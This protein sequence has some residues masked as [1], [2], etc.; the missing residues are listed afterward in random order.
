MTFVSIEFLIFAAIVMPLYYCLQRQWQNA[1]L[2]VAGYVFY[3]WWDFRFLGLLALSTLWDFCCAIAISNAQ[4]LRTRKLLLITSLTFSLCLLGFFKYFN[5]FVESAVALFNAF[6]YEP[7]VPLLNVVLPVGISFYTFQ[8]MSYTIDVYKGVTAPC[9]NFLTFAA[10]ISFFPQ[11]VAGPIER[12]AHILPQFES[13]RRVTCDNVSQGFL[14]ILLGVFKKLGVADALAPMVDLFFTYPQTFSGL[15]LLIGI[16]F[17][18]I[19]IYCD[20][21][22]YTDIARGVAKLLGFELMVN[23]N[24]PYFATSITEFWRRWHISL[25]TWLRDYLYIPLGGNRFGTYNTYR[26]LMLTMLIGGLWHGA[27]WCFVIWGFLH[28][29]FL[30]IHKLVLDFRENR[31][32]VPK[33]N[34]SVFGRIIAMI[35]TFHLVAFAWIFFR[36]GNLEKALLYCKGILYWQSGEFWLGAI[37]LA[38]AIILVAILFI[39]DLSQFRASDHLLFLRWKWWQQAMLYSAAI[40]A[41]LTCGGLNEDVPFIYFQF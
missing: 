30:T 36:A 11:L 2:L 5:F 31:R 17:F 6:G 10:F 7:Y 19:Q 14:L 32:T 21:S 38:R 23:F 26:N 8:S 39:I 29:L 34:P 3:G 12:A 9:R 4:S 16:Y 24:Q 15:T 35:A 20:F 22:G 27:S 18:T 37:D 28:G 25:S 13:P 33:I 41:L 40:I 1:L